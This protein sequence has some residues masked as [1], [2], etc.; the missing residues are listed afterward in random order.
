MQFILLGFDQRAKI[1]RYAFQGIA[2]RTRTEF[3]VGVDLSLLP[4]YGIHMQELPLLCRELLE[5]RGAAADGRALTF[6]E[7]EMGDY[8]RNCKMARDAAALNKK[9]PRRS[10]STQIGSAWRSP[11]D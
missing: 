7:E 10:P 1:R 6:T 4:R 3:T 9:A 2:D 5:R 8:A 11:R